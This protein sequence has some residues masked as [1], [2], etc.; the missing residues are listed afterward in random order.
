MRLSIEVRF[1]PAKDTPD[2]KWTGDW[3]GGD[4]Y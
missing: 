3:K 4:G 1:I 2:S